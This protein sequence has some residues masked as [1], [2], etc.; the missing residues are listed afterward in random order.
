MLERFRARARDRLGG[1]REALEAE[2]PVEATRWSAL[3]GDLHTLK[4]E[5]RMLG[6]GSAAELCHGIESQLQKP[7][8]ALS[9]TRIGAASAGLDALEAMLLADVLSED[10]EARAL[11]EA[12]QAIMEQ[13][14]LT[15][16]PPAA[17]AAPAVAPVPAPVMSA[18]ADGAG[19]FEGTAPTP[20]GAGGAPELHRGATRGDRVVELRAAQLDRVCDAIEELRQRLSRF[21]TEASA[22]VRS[23]AEELAAE[24][25]RL[26]VDSAELRLSRVEP[27]LSTLA[28]HARVLAAQGGRRVAIRVEAGAAVLERG[29]LDALEE[30]LLHL[31]RNAVDHGVA[32][33]AQGRLELSAESRGDSVVLAVSDDGP[34]I[35]T[36]AIRRAVVERGLLSPERL[37][38]V[39]EEL[40]DLIFTPGLSTRSEVSDVSGRGMGLDVVR[41]V[42]ES[43]GG[44]VSV[45]SLPGQGSRF[46]LEVPVRLTRERVAVVHAGEAL[47]GIPSR[48]VSSIVPC[49]GARTVVGGGR[50]LTVGELSLPLHSLSDLIGMATASEEKLALVVEVAGRSWALSVPA[51]E[52]EREVLRRPVD[53]PLATLPTVGA[54]AVLDDGRPLLMPVL[55]ELVR[56]SGIRGAQRSAA[57]QAG[58]KAGFATRRGRRVLVVDDSP[59]VRELLVELLLSM[60]LEVTQAPDGEA[61]LAATEA[62]D[63]DLIISDVEMPAIDGFELVRRLR[64]RGAQMPIIVVTTRGSVEDR[65]HAAQ[66]GADAYVVKTD[67][68]DSDLVEHVKRLMDLRP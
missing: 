19:R 59:I 42:T 1:L 55:A 39:Q 33:G 17:V 31:V 57:G 9:A 61:G 3:M 15:P 62:D 43:L 32:V 41:R 30:P 26:A 65:R 8:G 40:L 2:Q 34:G 24:V 5:A 49:A 45:R 38:Q 23:E 66:C 52:G 29:V 20:V 54:S 6:L 63:F 56:K 21:A 58:L 4:G 7:G 14:A 44:A 68:R 22:A 28:A 27:V 11:L 48:Q 37:P 25:E 36:A 47:F 35:D 50:A 16:A 64:A 18:P 67:F 46:V 12:A 60:G 53:R 10:D 51:V 13:T